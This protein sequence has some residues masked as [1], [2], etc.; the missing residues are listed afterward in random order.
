MKLSNYIKIY[1]PAF[2]GMLALTFALRPVPWARGLKVG[3]AFSVYLLLQAFLSDRVTR[4]KRS[5]GGW[6][7][8]FA[9]AAVSCIAMWAVDE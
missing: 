5:L 8:T 4:N 6:M 2:L 9:L 1:V 3:I 7:F